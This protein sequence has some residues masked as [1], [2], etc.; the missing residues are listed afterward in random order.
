MILNKKLN[1]TTKQQDQTPAEYSFSPSI[2]IRYV[3]IDY[4]LDQ[5]L[6]KFIRTEII[7]SVFSDH[8]GPYKSIIER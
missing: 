8:N 3:K 6:N 2:P 4:T 5:N 7:Q 1:H